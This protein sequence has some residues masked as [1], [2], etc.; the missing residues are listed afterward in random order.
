M[1]C[2]YV[3]CQP[4]IR[5][6]PVMAESLSGPTPPDLAGLVDEWLAGLRSTNTRAAYSADLRRFVAW[7]EA[8]DLDPLRLDGRELRR[9]R[10]SIERS[11]V[12]SS[13]TARRLSVVASFGAYASARG[14][15]AEFAEVARP[16]VTST[17]ATATLGDAE[18]ESLLHAADG[19]DARAGVLIR[20]LML[21]GLKVGEATASDAADVTGR[22]PA[23]VLGVG[24]RTVALHPD[25]GALLH[26]YL[27]RRREGPLLL[28]E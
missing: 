14:A 9:Y 12:S 21:D 1:C 13:T 4:T 22:P 7:C 5:E 19:L 10:A 24:R 18:A 6:N 8:H 27:G 3:D 11:G 17:R 16:Q 25:T 23:L 2:H 28:S 15:A 26:A 20:L